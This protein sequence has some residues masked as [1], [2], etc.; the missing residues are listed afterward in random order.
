SRFQSLDAVLALPDPLGALK[1]AQEAAK[2]S[3]PWSSID[4]APGP[5]TA[6]RLPPL[7]A[8]EVWA[9]GATYPHREEDRIAQSAQAGDFYESVFK[10][11]RPELFLKATAHRVV[12]PQAPIR[13]RA[14]STKDVPGPELA[15]VLSPSLRVVGFTVG[16]DVSSRSLEGENPLYLPQAKIYDGC[17]ALGP[18]ILM[19]EPDIDPLKLDVR[20]IIRR[21]NVEIFEGFV[22]TSQMT[23]KLEDLIA[24]LGRDNSFPK[25][26]VLLT[27]TGVIAPADFS[28]QDGDFVEI[29]IPTIGTLRNPVVRGS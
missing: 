9:A 17:C 18:A 25:G 20:L 24:Y 10:A 8:A 2:P 27:G 1:E 5:T 16:N 6:H 14:D 13:L 22:S 3:I 7:E 26:A 12:G 21:N 15:L 23:R 28:L 29:S 19:A 11:D 4:R